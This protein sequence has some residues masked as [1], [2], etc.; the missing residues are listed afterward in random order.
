[1]GVGDWRRAVRATPPGSDDPNL[2]L[3]QKFALQLADAVPFK[4]VFHTLF[5]GETSENLLLPSLALLPPQAC[6]FG[7]ARF[8]WHGEHRR[9]VTFTLES[10]G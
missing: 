2:G 1:L 3:D 6:K 9:V 7:L 4:V 10:V 8:R 5:K